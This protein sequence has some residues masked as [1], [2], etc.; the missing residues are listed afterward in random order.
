MPGGAHSMVTVLLTVWLMHMAVMVSPGVNTLLV[1]Q[2]AAS[3][4][5]GSVRFA[6]L[7]IC[8]GTTFWAGAA[9][10]GVQALFAAMPGVRL[11]LQVAGGVYLLYLA[12]R[13]WRAPAT[14]WHTAPHSL[15]P[16]AAYRL[17]LLTNLTN[18][19]AVLFFSSVFATAFPPDP[20]WALQAMAAMVAVLNA[21]FWH[22]FL[23]KL[24]AD[25]RIQG[26][27]GRARGL[28]NRV[29]A[30]ALGGFGAAML[31]ATL[32]EARHPA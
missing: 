25:A 26:A 16:W 5:A 19:K 28:A 1:S 8:T 15:R 13:L 20:G 23:G 30:L 24:F 9:L 4:R 22:L 6:V 29:S 2:L 21:F 14:A 31:V 32:R 3:G 18:P 10:F 17:G 12:S 11:A 7:G 27:Y